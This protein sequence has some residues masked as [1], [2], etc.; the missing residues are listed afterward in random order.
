MLGDLN[1]IQRFCG[2]ARRRGRRAMEPWCTS[3]REVN[4][5]RDDDANTVNLGRS[6]ACPG[7]SGLFQI[8]VL[9]QLVLSA[10]PGGQLASRCPAT[11]AFRL[12]VFTHYFTRIMPPRLVPPANSTLESVAAEPMRLASTKR[13][14]CY[15]H[16]RRVRCR[17][18]RTTVRGRLD[19]DGRGGWWRSKAGMLLDVISTPF[20]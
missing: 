9:G 20:F 8:K 18:R 14:G 2:P 7:D 17:C 13:S 4:V 15:P 5:L 10:T 11:L 16:D 19:N 6:H 12:V 3:P 1:N